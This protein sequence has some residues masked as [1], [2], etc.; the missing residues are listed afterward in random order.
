M[1]LKLIRTWRASLSAFIHLNGIEWFWMKVSAV[2]SL[3]RT[4]ELSYTVSA[5]YP[6]RCLK[7]ASYSVD[8]Q[9]P[10]PVVFDW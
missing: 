3:G 2:R 9:S 4:I 1:L 5:Y 10:A 6:Q 8:A 7:A